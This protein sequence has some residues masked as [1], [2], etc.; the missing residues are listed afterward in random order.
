MCIHT[1]KLLEKEVERKISSFY[2]WKA[3]AKV[4]IKTISLYEKKVP[5]CATYTIK[6]YSS[7]L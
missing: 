6:I 2:F 5:S 3:I 4:V 7:G 1:H